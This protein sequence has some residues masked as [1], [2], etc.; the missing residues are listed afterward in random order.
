MVERNVRDDRDPAV[1]GMSGVE[2]PAQPH[3]DHRQIDAGLG[4][5]A[6]CDR[7][8]QLELRRLA[9]ASGDAVGQGE[10]LAGDA[11]ERRRIHRHAIDLESLAVRDQVRLGRLAG[12][13]S[14]GLERRAHEREDAAFAVRARDQR[15]SELTLR[16][17]QARE[18]SPRPREPQVDPETAARPEGRQRLDVSEPG[19]GQSFVSSS[20]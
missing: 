18:Q 4:E 15:P 17:A 13:V 9:V 8:Q 11:G 12:P 19:A 5:P 3:L 10:N 16:M 2:P 1:P 14:G 6:E 7:R 20:S